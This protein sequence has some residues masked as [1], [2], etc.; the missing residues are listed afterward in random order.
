M[1]TAGLDLDAIDRLIRGQVGTFDTACP[2]CSAFRSSPANR[3]AKVF[4]IYR[5]DHGFAGYHCVHCGESGY[6]RDSHATSL[7]PVTL[8][9]ARAD[10]AERD[11]KHKA[12]RLNKARWLW[13]QRKPVIGSFAET[14]LRTKRGIG[15]RLPA[16]LGFLPAHGEY[17]PA[18]IAAVG[19]PREVDPGVIAIDDDAVRGVHM[20]RL[21]PDGSDRER[22]KEAKKTVGRCIGWP[23]VLAPPNDLLGL[24]IA[25]GIENVLVAHEATGLGTWAAGGASRLPALADMLPDWIDCVTIIADDDP[26]GRRHAG[27]LARRIEA[28]GI[29]TVVAPPASWRDT[30]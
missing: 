4:R 24:A 16:T 19:M 29:E 17:P 7:D 18:L 12:E 26:D 20:V 30:A 2:F 11:R 6:A 28:R 3:R 27:V 1:T 9:K 14:Y 25:E 13:S 22:H 8:A 5:T 23:I 10:A 15:C 21:L